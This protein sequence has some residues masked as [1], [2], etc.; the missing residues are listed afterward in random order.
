MKNLPKGS[1]V[2][3]STSRGWAH[4]NNVNILIPSTWTNVSAQPTQSVHE[5]AQIRVE[6]SSPVYGDSPFTVQ[7]GDCG[8]QGEYIQVT[9]NFLTQQVA[10]SDSVFGPAGQV[11]V[12]EWSRFRYGVFEEHGYPGDPLY[13]M[14]YL[15]QVGNDERPLVEVRP[16]FCTNTEPEGKVI[17]KFYL[18]DLTSVCQDT[19]RRY[20][21]V[22]AST[23]SPQVSQMTTVSL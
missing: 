14:F 20:Q 10:Q 16:N 6:S 1:K 3:H 12:Y 5:D 17:A 15:K 18:L 11:F 4:I 8:D 23:M 13:P 19:L 21:A 22:T 2:L 9:E 7:T